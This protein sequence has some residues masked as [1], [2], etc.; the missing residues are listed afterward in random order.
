MCVDSRGNSHRDRLEIESGGS[1]TD[2]TRRRLCGPW[3]DLPR[4]KTA[5]TATSN[6]VTQGQRLLLSCRNSPP[7]TAGTDL[8]LLGEERVFGKG[9]WKNLLLLLLRLLRPHI[10]AMVD[11]AQNTKLFTYYYSSSSSSFFFFF[12]FF[13]SSPSSSSSSCFFFYFL[14]SSSSSSSS[15]SLLLLLH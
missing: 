8:P 4:V 11:W 3:H 13:S 7:L 9:L 10:T 5:L 12:F 6:T 14:F 1:G 2:G 15:S